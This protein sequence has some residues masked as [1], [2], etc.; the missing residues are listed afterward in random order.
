MGF[1]VSKSYNASAIQLLIG[2]VPITG[3]SPDDCVSFEPTGSIASIQEGADGEKTVSRQP[4]PSFKGKITLA[5]AATANAAILALTIAQR[6]A[7]PTNLLPFF[8]FDPS[9][10]E[11]IAAA[12]LVFS[13][14][15]S[16]GKGREAG[17]R[18]W[19]FILPYPVFTPAVL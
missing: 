1:S 18:E 3:F 10:G 8:M 13:D 17:T 7:G 2:G 15:P 4:L 11:T 9:T 6:L 12:E 16:V 5:E 14:L 19:G